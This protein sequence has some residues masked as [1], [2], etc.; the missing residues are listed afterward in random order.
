MGTVTSYPQQSSPTGDDWLMVVDVQDAT[1]SP[2][3]STKKAL[4]S[5]LHTPLASLIGTDLGI[6]FQVT[7]PQWLVS[8][9]ESLAFTSVT[10][11]SNEA[12]TSAT[13]TWPDGTT[14]TWTADV[15]STT[16]PGAVD[17][18]HVTYGAHTVTQPQVTRDSSGAVSAQ[19]ALTVT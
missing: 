19:P 15:L 9:V 3:G 12:V 10:R 1:E 6:G 8:A 2:A 11:N 5:S 4:I 17:A 16:F 18:Y 14:G 7:L 13:V